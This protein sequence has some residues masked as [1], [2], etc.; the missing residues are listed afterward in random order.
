MSVDP[1][2]MQGQS[3][4]IL[5][6]GGYYQPHRTFV[7]EMWAAYRQRPRISSVASHLDGSLTFT[8]ENLTPNKTN[9]IQ[10]TADLS[11]M[12][13]TTIRTNLLATDTFRFLDLPATNRPQRFYRVQ[14]T[15]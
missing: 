1:D 11:S 9:F 7:D 14:Q 5:S 13:W 8:V 10:V 2:F 3:W 12:N 15:L 4:K 6:G